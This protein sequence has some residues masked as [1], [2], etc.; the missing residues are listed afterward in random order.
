MLRVYTLTCNYLNVDTGEC[1]T[2]VL[3][4]YQEFESAQKEMEKNIANLKKE[5]SHCDTE[6]SNYVKG[7]M[8]YSIWE[9]GQYMSYHCDLIIECVRLD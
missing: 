7:D 5:F 4:V 6:D 2:C 9:K 1:D 3:G 8:S